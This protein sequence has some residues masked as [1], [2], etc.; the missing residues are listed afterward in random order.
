MAP[1][2]NILAW[3]I[4]W[5]EEPVGYSP[6]GQKESDSMQMTF[7]VSSGYGGKMRNL[8]LDNLD[9]NVIS[10]YKLYEFRQET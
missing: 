4:P 5:T 10:V 8:G 6:W 2:S 1:H 9:S 3:R 7:E